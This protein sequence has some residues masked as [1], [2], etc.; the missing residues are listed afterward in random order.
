MKKLTPNQIMR[1]WNE[2]SLD[3]YYN[4]EEAST[5]YFYNIY[6]KQAK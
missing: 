1:L 5:W 6:I 2:Y 4:Q 3:C